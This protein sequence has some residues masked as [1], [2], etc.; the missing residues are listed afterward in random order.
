MDKAIVVLHGYDS[1]GSQK[2]EKLKKAFPDYRV[3]VPDLNN[4]VETN[5]DTILHLIAWCLLDYEEVHIVGTSLGGFYAL[6]L[7]SRLDP[8]DEVD[9]YYYLINPALTPTK[10]L[11]KIGAVLSEEDYE[12]LAVREATMS[13]KGLVGFTFFVGLQD[14]V[15]PPSEL[16]QAL[17]STTDPHNIVLSDQDHRHSDITA[18]IEHIKAN[19]VI[20][21]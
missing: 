16:V 21:L 6:D 15:I 19:S 18:V 9:V 8:V 2:A 11:P 12:S 10:T 3:F 17:E 7:Y 1:K 14:D 20:T 5:V 4:S 13:L